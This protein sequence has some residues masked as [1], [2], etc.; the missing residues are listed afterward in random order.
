M[1]SLGLG[2]RFGSQPHIPHTPLLHDGASSGDS[3]VK[4]CKGKLGLAMR[5]I[6]K[7]A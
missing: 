1:H 7:Y 2:L 5:I 6:S 3:A 4:G